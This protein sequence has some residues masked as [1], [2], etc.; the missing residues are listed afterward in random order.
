[1]APVTQKAEKTGSQTPEQGAGRTVTQDAT[2]V[3]SRQIGQKPGPTLAHLGRK[4]EGERAHNAA[5]HPYAVEGIEEADDE[6]GNQRKLHDFPRK[7]SNAHVTKMAGKP[8]APNPR[9][10]GLDRCGLI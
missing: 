7:R 6:A 3:V 1:M 2:A 8:T 10:S 5:T 4:A 9:I